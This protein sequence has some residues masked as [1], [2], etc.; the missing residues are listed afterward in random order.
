MSTGTQRLAGTKV[1]T[2]TRQ[3]TLCS[4]WDASNSSYFKNRQLIITT[5]PFYLWTRWVII[6]GQDWYMSVFI[7]SIHQRPCAVSQIGSKWLF[8]LTRHVIHAVC[9]AFMIEH[10]R[11]RWAN[12]NENKSVAQEEQKECQSGGGGSSTTVV[13]WFETDYSRLPS[14]VEWWTQW[15]N[16]GLPTTCFI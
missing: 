15:I 14:S 7:L 1:D 9:T 12:L 10:I 6:V 11:C 2:T 4:V 5:K 13:A 16:S 8:K 3:R